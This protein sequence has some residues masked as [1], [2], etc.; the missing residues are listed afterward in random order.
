MNIGVIVVTATAAY[1][2]WKEK[3]NLYGKIAIAVGISSILLLK[4]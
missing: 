1:L 4:L 2:I 3:I